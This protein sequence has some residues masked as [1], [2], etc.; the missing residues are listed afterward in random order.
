MAA[1]KKTKDDDA[2]KKTIAN[3]REFVEQYLKDIVALTEDDGTL[4]ITLNAAIEDGDL[5]VRATTTNTFE[6]EME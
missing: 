4:S 2:T 1:K 6:D 3:T 5:Y